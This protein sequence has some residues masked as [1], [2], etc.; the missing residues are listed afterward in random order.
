MKRLPQEAVSVI[1]RSITIVGCLGFLAVAL[2]NHCRNIEFFERCGTN[3]N[4]GSIDCSHLGGGDPPIWVFC[5]PHPL[6]I[7]PSAP[8]HKCIYNADV[9]MST[10]NPSGTQVYAQ[11]QDYECTGVGCGVAPVGEPEDYGL[12]C[13]SATLS[14]QT[15]SH[16]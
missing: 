11:K 16:E 2:G 1:R 8:V 10:C 6:Y 5:E 3:Q 13:S 4:L 7:V 9:G 14:G 12:P 15:C